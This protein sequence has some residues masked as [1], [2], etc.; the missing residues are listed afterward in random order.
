MTVGP[1]SCVHACVHSWGWALSVCTRSS[2]GPR[3]PERL[4]NSILS[5]VLLFFSVLKDI[6][7]RGLDLPQ[8]TWI[9][10]VT[11]LVVMGRAWG[12]NVRSWADALAWSRV[13]IKT[14]LGVALVPRQPPVPSTPFSCHFSLPQ[15]PW[16][17]QLSLQAVQLGLPSSQ[18]N[19]CHTPIF[20]TL[21][22]MGTTGP[23]GGLIVSGR[24]WLSCPENCLHTD[25]R[26]Q[27]RPWQHLTHTSSL[28]HLARG[29]GC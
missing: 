6:A 22:I 1:W 18:T 4:R 19:T 10:Q 15:P 29:Y 26:G 23:L 8:V 28:R 12:Q 11:S 14:L 27:L 17:P 9:V 21:K 20:S 24:R 2:N 5:H 3:T 7:A 13:I 16:P 25:L